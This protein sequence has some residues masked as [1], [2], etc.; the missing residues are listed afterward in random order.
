MK[1]LY[2]FALAALVAL[3][4]AAA[5]ATKVTATRTLDTRSVMQAVESSRTFKTLET[6]DLQRMKAPRSAKSLLNAKKAASRADEEP[7]APVRPDF[8]TLEFGDWADAGTCNVNLGIF[9]NFDKQNNFTPA[10]QIAPQLNVAMQERVCK[11]NANIKQIVL[12]NVS[13]GNYF[14]TPVDLTLDCLFDES[15][16]AIVWFHTNIGQLD[17][18]DGNGGSV[19]FDVYF[20]DMYTMFMDGGYDLDVEEQIYYY[21]SSFYR[22]LTGEFTLSSIMSLPNTG[23]DRWS[24]W[25]EAYRSSDITRIGS[26]Y[27]NLDFDIEDLEIVKENGKAYMKFNAGLNDLSFVW[28]AVKDAAYAQTTSTRTWAMG[29]AQGTD[30]DYEEITKD[31]EVKIEIPNAEKGYYYLYFLTAYGNSLESYG[32]RYAYYDP[33]WDLYGTATYFDPFCYGFFGLGNAAGPYIP[34]LKVDV[35]KNNQK[36]GYYRI[37][38]PYATFR[39]TQ[40]GSG[41]DVNLLVY[42]PTAGE[43]NNLYFNVDDKGNAYIESFSTGLIWAFL[44]DEGEEVDIPLTMGAMANDDIESEGSYDAAI[45]AYPED[46]GTF[47]EGVLY[48]PCDMS[49]A[50]KENS[51]YYTPLYFA[52]TKDNSFNIFFDQPILKM[53]D[54]AIRDIVNDAAVDAN[55]PVEYFNLQGIRVANPENGLYIRRQGRTVSKVLVK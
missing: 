38:N 6:S 34:E 42:S 26:E 46:F 47:K 44:D 8:K 10:Y 4:A 41:A 55:A 29:V 13:F 43:D 14:E 48:F 18:N 32:G 16:D 49:E 2:S 15:G 27:K 12:K 54:S 25:V 39:Q 33:D 53:D 17:F 21:D 9:G 1:K 35:E 52:L 28:Y 11:T 30:T 37:V 31:G 22:A 7:T 3:S 20:T 24:Y 50:D 51:D 45:A 40:W 19:T 36:E 23:S 5:P